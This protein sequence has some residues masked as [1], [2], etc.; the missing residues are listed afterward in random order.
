MYISVSQSKTGNEGNYKQKHRRKRTHKTETQSKIQ[1][2]GESHGQ[3]TDFDLD[4]DMNDV[5]EINKTGNAFDL[6][7]LQNVFDLALAL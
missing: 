6:A 1:R 2:L 7:I 3:R 5:Q 4:S